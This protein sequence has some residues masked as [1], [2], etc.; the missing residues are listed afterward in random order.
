MIFVLTTA[1]QW[2]TS[3]LGQAIGLAVG[4]ALALWT[5]YYKGT[6]AGQ[7]EAQ[8]KAAQAAATRQHERNKIEADTAALP[9]DDVRSQLQRDWSS[10]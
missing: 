9:I 3:K 10:S 5:V 4:V 2:I 7:A 8:A 6:R 1:W